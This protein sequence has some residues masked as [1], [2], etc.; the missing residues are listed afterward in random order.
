MR[1]GGFEEESCFV[2]YLLQE[3]EGNHK[4]LMEECNFTFAWN[5]AKSDTTPGVI[6]TFFTLHKWYQI[7]QI[8]SYFWHGGGLDQQMVDIASE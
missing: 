2:V 5:F 7:G 1:P 4:T 6:F 3:R 8:D